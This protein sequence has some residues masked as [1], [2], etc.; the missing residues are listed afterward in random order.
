M[1]TKR[2][3]LVVNLPPF[4]RERMESRLGWLLSNQGLNVTIVWR[5]ASR[6]E[7]P[8]FRIASN[9]GAKVED[10]VRR[11]FLQAVAEAVWL[12]PLAGPP[13]HLGTFSI[14]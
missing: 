3:T 12:R 1:Q 10:T 8:E 5:D 13:V 4:L 11:V 2:A 9:A 14:E 7:H 6:E